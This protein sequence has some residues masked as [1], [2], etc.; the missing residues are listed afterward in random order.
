ME[1]VSLVSQ[2]VSQS[3][4]LVMQVFAWRGLGTQRIYSVSR[5]RL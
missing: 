5:L 3:S 2:S 1:L 4:Q